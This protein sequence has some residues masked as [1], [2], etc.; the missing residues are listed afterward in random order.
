MTRTRRTRA[1]KSAPKPTRLEDGTLQVYSYHPESGLYVGTDVAFA[2]PLTPGEFL[3]PAS[4]TQVEPPNPDNGEQVR[5][6][7]T[8]WIVE[9]ITTELNV[10]RSDTQ[11]TDEQQSEQVKALRDA[12]LRACD[13]TMLSDAPLSPAQRKT[14]RDY[15][16]SLRDITKQAGFPTNINWPEKP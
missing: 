5:W 14:W 12:I 4:A 2:D 8:N 11:L 1:P 15:R 6:V 7:G 13:W 10:F 3:I 9:P 16:K